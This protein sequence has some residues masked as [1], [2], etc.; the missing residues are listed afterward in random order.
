MGNNNRN[1]NDNFNFFNDK[2][3]RINVVHFLRRFKEKIVD[4]ISNRIMIE[5]FK[6]KRIYK[7]ICA[8]IDKREKM[9]AKKK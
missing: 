6:N 2:E 4:E 9:K 7:I 8:E 3:E 5:L 1:S